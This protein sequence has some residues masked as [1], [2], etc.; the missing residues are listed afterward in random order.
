[1]KFAVRLVDRAQQIFEDELVIDWKGAI[2]AL[3]QQLE[4]MF[5]KQAYRNDLSGLGHSISS[6][7]APPILTHVRKIGA[8]RFASLTAELS[9]K[10]STGIF[11]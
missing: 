8:N 5:R 6:S 2:E 10:L 9:P 7:R 4:L 3:A 1:L 11:A